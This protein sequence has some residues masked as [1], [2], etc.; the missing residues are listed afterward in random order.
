[1]EFLNGKRILITGGTGSLGEKLVRE[2]LTKTNIKKIYIYSRD[3]M[4]QF[5]LFESLD[6]NKKLEFFIGDIKRPGYYS[7]CI[8]DGDGWRCVTSWQ[9][10]ISVTNVLGD[11]E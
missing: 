6:K 9:P 1:M 5:L 8:K 7:E 11:G 10:Q 3:E 2:I 4:K